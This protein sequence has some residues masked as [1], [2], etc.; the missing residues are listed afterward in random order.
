MAYAAFF[1]L[2]AYGHL[3]PALG[4]VRELTARGERIVF[5]STPPF[6][7]VI[8][9]AGAEYRP[10][11][12][13]VRQ[14]LRGVPTNTFGFADWIV[15]DAAIIVPGLIDALRAD[16]PRYILHDGL[17]LWGRLLAEILG[18]PAVAVFPTFVL[19]PPVM[20]MQPRMAWRVLASLP[21]GLPAVRRM[22]RT[23][24]RMRRDYGVS[25]AP[26]PRALLNKGA[27]SIAFVDR[28]F[29]PAPWSCGKN[30]VFAGPSIEGPRQTIAFPM[31]RLTG[32]PLV[33][34]S[35]G[36]LFNERPGFYCMA[37]EALAHLD[38]QIVMATGVY[39]PPESLGPLPAN[40]LAVTAIP[41]LELLERAAVFITHGGMNS[42][43]EGLWHGVPLLTVPQIDEQR[44]NGERAAA[45]G[46]GLVLGPERATAPRLRRA[47]ERLLTEP[48]FAQRAKAL[49][50]RFRQ[51]G[52][53]ARAASEVIAFLEGQDRRTAG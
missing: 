51:G 14:D 10:H 48:R 24:A 4:L 6:R 49:G 30:T 1:C 23:A 50:Q 34:L 25:I 13:G 43:S 9:A 39:T 37:A 27:L 40:C 44:L 17:T 45:L 31:E 21:A 20:V 8:E 5:Y 26:G 3:N 18:V 32:K 35:L 11:P 38:A 29:Q 47:V 19:D 28:R 41:Q 53:A 16:P 7:E 52:G 33:L 12:E 36:T 22:K 15:E 46:A 2:P 42:V